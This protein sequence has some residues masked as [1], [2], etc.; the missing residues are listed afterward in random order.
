[1]EF[2]L[3]IDDSNSS[4]NTVAVIANVPITKESEMSPALHFLRNIDLK[5]EVARRAAV[6]LELHNYGMSLSGGPV[7]IKDG[8]KVVAYEQRFKLTK[9]I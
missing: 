7:P 4:G 9:N 6:E 1:M 2:K 5:N 8:D 3:R